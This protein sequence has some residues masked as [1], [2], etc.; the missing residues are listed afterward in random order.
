MGKNFITGKIKTKI[1]N[2]WNNSTYC[3]QNINF[4]ELK[5]AINWRYCDKQEKI[6]LNQQIMQSVNTTTPGTASYLTQNS[7]S[8]SFAFSCLHSRHY[9]LPCEL[10]ASCSFLI[11]RTDA[12]SSTILWSIGKGQI[13][14]WRPQCWQNW[15]TDP[16][17]AT[18]YL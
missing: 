13:T 5:D 16:K 6:Q 4:C 18:S 8:I 1:I 14:L 2:K 15:A 7:L 9:K 11:K 17:L 3:L 12:N 10:W